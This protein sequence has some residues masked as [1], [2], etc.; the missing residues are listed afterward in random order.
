[1]PSTPQKRPS[2]SLRPSTV[3]STSTSIASALDGTGLQRISARDGR[4]RP[5]LNPSRALFLDSWSDV[6]T[7]PQVRLHR[8]STGDVVRVVHA[9]PVPALTEYAL[10][11]PE[12]LQ[13]KT[14]D[15][16]V[17]EAM[18]IKPPDFDP[19]RRYPGLPVHLRGTSRPAGRERLGR[20][21][22]HV[23]PAARAAR[24]HRLDHATTAPRAARACSRRGRSIGTSARWSC[25]TSR[26]AFAWLK[27]QPYVD[28]SRIGISGVSFGGF[29]TLYA[30]TH[31]RSF[32]MGIAEGAV[33]DWR[34]YDSI[35]TERY[36]G[37][38]QDNAE[39]YRR[40]SPRFS[41][42]SL[43]GELLLIHSTLDDN[44]HP[45]N[46]MQFAYELQK[47]GQAVSDDDVSQIGAWRQRPAARAAPSADDARFHAEESCAIGCLNEFGDSSMGG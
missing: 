2:F 31:S 21:R 18:M 36:M 26:T 9:N 3:P 4:H 42:A 29:M 45:Q 5:F 12:L 33:T 30:L 19:S 14:R 34:N 8:T 38:P 35:Y 25:G 43:S 32:A 7:P 6:N 16:F 1:M 44:V 28:G 24:R 10:S 23:P 17:M 47:A 41:A 40:S 13:V 46:A 39:G 37:L 20:H 15:G 11:R 22:L 27:A